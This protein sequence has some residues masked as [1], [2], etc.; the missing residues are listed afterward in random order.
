MPKW[1]AL[2]LLPGAIFIKPDY[3]QYL[4]F[5]T[6]IINIM[7]DFSPLVEPFS[8][9]EAYIDIS[10]TQNIFGSNVEIARQIKKRIWEEIGVLCSV[11]IG[12]NKLVAKMAAEIQKPDGLTVI[13]IKDVPGKLWPLPVGE[14]FGVG[15]KTEKKLRGLRYRS[16]SAS[17]SQR[18]KLQPRQPTLPGQGQVCRKPADLKP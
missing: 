11:G 15:R 6:R 5:S 17:F 8:I 9:D 2:N 16:R 12:P 10:G 4:D 13:T 14:L 3:R 7:R 18:Y 1:E